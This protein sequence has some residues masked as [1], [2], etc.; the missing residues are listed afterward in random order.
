MRKL[1]KWVF[2]GVAFGAAGQAGCGPAAP[3]SSV[4]GESDGAEPESVGVGEELSGA[5]VAK[6]VE[7]TCSTTSVK[8]LSEQLVAQINCLVPGA[9]AKVPA[10]PNLSPGPAAFMFLQTAA[11]DALV[12][13]LDQNP[14]KTLGVNSMYRTVAQQYLLQRWKKAGRC[15]VS[16]AASPGKSN[17]ESGLA[18]DTSQY[19]TWKGALAAKGFDWF[20]SADSVHFDYDGPGKKSL[21]GAGVRAFQIL[22]NRNHP[23]DSIDEDGSF[24]PETAARLAKAPADGFPLGASCGAPPPP[25]GTGGAGGAGGAGGGGSG[26]G[27]SGGGPG[28]GGGNAGGAGGGGGGSGIWSPAP[29]A[30]WQWQLTGGIDTSV[31]ASMFDIDLFDVGATTI[32]ALHAKGRTV[33]C[34]FSAGSRESWRGDAGQFASADHGSPLDGW[35]GET[36]LDT[37]SA[38]VRAIMKKR[39]DLAVQKQCDGVEPDNV[40]AYQ[41][42]SGFPLTAATQKD[43]LKFLS[44]EAHARGLS[45]G[46]KN[47]LGLIPAVVS[48]FD[49]A[50]N[51]QCLEYDECS[52]MAPFINAGKAV[53]HVEYVSSSSASAAKKAQVCGA[54]STSGFSTLIK[55]LDL[56][57]WRVT[58]P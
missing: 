17:H 34:Y 2:V 23:G 31:P 53:F 54:A 9:L 1:A 58:C 48:D 57:A 33:I 12:Q 30:T 13:A 8:G 44:S 37:R 5:T 38:N 32:D 40:D 26:G 4:P 27:G 11:R 25:G 56:G 45:I 6:A 29:G 7:A 24:G 51:E 21:A 42:A 41:N 20:G 28:G 15:G 18:I 22:W 47:A 3:E 35:A 14:A 19:G 36:W 52:A 43:Y 50:L 46:L 16:A 49:W 39:L 55:T 10:R